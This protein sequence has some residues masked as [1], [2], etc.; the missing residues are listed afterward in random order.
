MQILRIPFHHAVDCA[1]SGCL[2][3]AA[4][5]SWSQEP[6]KTKTAAGLRQQLREEVTITWEER[7]LRSG[8]QR[9]SEVYGIAIF[10]DRRIDP[11]LPINA[12][13]SQ[14]PLQSFLQQVASEAHGGITAIGPVVYVGPL[15]TTSQLTAMAAARR[16]EIGKLSNEAKAR[17]L[18]VASWQWDELAQPRQLLDELASQ[19]NVKI[20]NAAAIPLDLWPAINLPPLAWSDRLTLLL[21]GFGLTFEVDQAGATARLVSATIHPAVE[22]NSNAA[23]APAPTNRTAKPNKNAKESKGNDKLYTLTVENRAAA[24]VVALIAKNIGKEV[25]ADTAVREALTQK[26]KFTVKDA[27]LDYLMEMTLKPLGLRY[28]LT[29]QALVIERQ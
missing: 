7:G 3:L 28:R 27:T 6:T 25:Q 26:V 10:L 20:E 14:Q 15:E 23:A 17:L 1:F 2:L 9:L 4:S 24:E 22:A 11:G 18:H 12:A 16:Q 29:E 13:A 19:A 8:L 5:A 21:A